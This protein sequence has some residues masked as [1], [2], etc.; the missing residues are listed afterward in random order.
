[1]N[2][3]ADSF[4]LDENLARL[5]AAFDQAID[6]AD[7]GAPTIGVPTAN[8]RSPT[9]IAPG[10]EKATNQVPLDDFFVQPNSVV[11]IRAPKSGKFALPDAPHRV[12]RFELRRQLGKGG[13]GIV[14]LAYDPKLER[15]VALKVPRPEML[16]SQDARRRLIREAL[17]A[18]EF[19][20]PNLV[21]VY[22]SGEIGPICFIAT[23]FC[24][25]QTL[26]QWL[27]RQAFPVPIRQT[28]RLI[29]TLA[30]AV[31]HAHDRGVLHRDLK[32]NNV[33]LQATK[34]DPNEQEPPPGSVVLR[35]DQFIPRIVDFGLAKLLERGGPSETT[36][37]QI[38]GTPKYMAPE[39]AQARHADVG[40]A[41]DVYA[42]G[43]ILYEMITGRAPYEGESD[44]EVL[45]Q[46]IEG[47]LI[48][49]RH[50]RKD[51][52]RDLEAI[53]LK[54]MHRVP[55]K[56]YRTA[57]DLADDLR[58]FLDD[59]PT[60]ARPLKWAGRAARWLR[61][62]DQAVALVMVTT[63]ASILLALGS[64]S[65]MQTRKLQTDRDRVL[66]TQAERTRGDQYR[67]YARAVRSAFLAWRT[68][69]SKAA[70]DYLDTAWRLAQ[71]GGQGTDFAYGYL[72]KLIAA[73]R[74]TIVCPA[75]AV[76]ALA[77]SADGTRLASGHANGSVTVWDRAT[78]E[79]LSSVQAHDKAVTHLAFA[80]SDTR[81]LSVGEM[82]KGV[83]TGLGW[84]VNP[85]GQI[86]P[87]AP[88]H[89]VLGKHVSCLTTS[90]DG[91]TALVGTERGEV[92]ELH[93]LDATKN[94]SVQLER[95]DP[96]TAIAVCEA[97]RA[98]LVGL[99]S[100]KVRRLTADLK[101]E[102]GEGGSAGRV[103]ALFDLGGRQYAAASRN[104]L[105]MEVV[106]GRAVPTRGAAEWVV[107]IKQGFAAGDGPGWILIRNGRWGGLP[108]GDVGDVRAGA[109]T[110]DHKTLFTA[111][112]DGVIRSWEFPSDGR[113]RASSMVAEV[114]AVGVHPD[115]RWFNVADA[116]ALV[117]HFG[118]ANE[119]SVPGQIATMRV[120]KEGGAE[121][122]T[123]GVE[124]RAPAAVI[125]EPNA[126]KEKARFVPPDGA[127]ATSVDLA[128]DGMTLA[129]GDDRG[130]VFVWNAGVGNLLGMVDFGHKRS[131]RRVAISNDGYTIAAASD[132][133]VGAWNLGESKPLMMVATDAQ[134]VFKLF[135]NS[136]R[137]AI[138]GRG[139]VVRVWN[140]TDGREELTLY[141]HVGRVTGL[142]VS[143]DGRTLVSGGAT[144]EVKM[145]DVR[146]GLELFGLRRHSG[147][148]TVIEFAAN[149]QLLVTAGKQLA[150]WDTARE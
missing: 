59:K 11:S 32:P 50:L 104:G 67:D 39:Q 41:A 125:R 34:D 149:G 47:N 26:S 89:R 12:G 144:G 109:V 117:W 150:V 81:L 93:L 85:I 48:Q 75:G 14:F 88:P 73:D 9:G 5:L 90:E 3:P 121:G 113:E 64:L 101:P 115:G 129:V 8:L 84:A 140:L 112:D 127:V 120:L 103:T 33:I 27:D 82:A 98:V 42:L 146:T 72:A 130:R 126:A 57:I 116:L 71:M 102:D 68:G 45:R 123:L 118:T 91:N 15:E 80:L 10:T 54:A 119:L 46:S 136:P 111:G 56:R 145:W 105:F 62:N 38:L 43:V 29:A 19:D 55:G 92:L 143:P 35:G 49:P 23:A 96:V 16:L 70:A 22:E 63:I 87:L 106:D 40:P 141:G 86:T 31:Q 17:A 6:G 28:A 132:E 135:P 83:E 18:A 110:R 60:L 2:D 36:T 76:T 138:A 52:P 148:V 114:T 74:L 58:R 21:P 107:P 51:V 134:T 78:G 79:Q 13:C 139:G 4:Q 128:P 95:L 100:G 142:G 66:Q 97:G 137:L 99:G 69:D 25:G 24:P 147:P 53:C 77:V 124:M 108:T 133:Q 94:R 131:I 37:R 61:R 1:M 44:V 7:E 20:H 122:T 65:I 30:E